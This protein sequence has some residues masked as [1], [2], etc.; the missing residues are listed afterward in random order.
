[1]GWMWRETLAYVADGENG[2]VIVDVT[3]KG[4]IHFEGSNDTAG[5]SNGVDVVGKLCIC[6]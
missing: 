6:S 4:L 3:N 5:T 1:M 2:I